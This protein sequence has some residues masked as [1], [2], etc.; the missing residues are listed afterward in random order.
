MQLRTSNSCHFEFIATSPLALDNFET[1]FY[2]ERRIVDLR[3]NFI[4]ASVAISVESVSFI[5]LAYT[6]INGSSFIIGVSEL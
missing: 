5:I 3:S 6:N 1:L 2:N 4:T